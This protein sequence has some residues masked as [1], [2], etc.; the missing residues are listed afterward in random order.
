MP[1]TVSAG[2]SCDL[3]QTIA[4]CCSVDTTRSLGRKGQ[5]DGRIV[6]L[7]DIG[8]YRQFAVLGDEGGLPVGCCGVAGSGPA[9]GPVHAAQLFAAD[10]SDK[11]YSFG[12]VAKDEPAVNA[13][14][15]SLAHDRQGLTLGSDYNQRLRPRIRTLGQLRKE[16]RLGRIDGDD[17]QLS[18]PGLLEGG[19]QPFTISIVL[20]DQANVIEAAAPRHLCQDRTL[21][22]IGES[23]PEEVAI[24]LHIG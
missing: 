8:E 7:F 3:P 19:S 5:S 22:G 2:W 14:I 24:V 15:D 13:F 20:V 10:L 17:P 23:R 11:T 18:I 9:G 1:G 4:D 6:G 16:A 12:R 21:G